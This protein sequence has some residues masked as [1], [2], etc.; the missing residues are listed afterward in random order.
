MLV[1]STDQGK[2]LAFVMEGGLVWR[3]T[4]V[5]VND[6]YRIAPNSE[7]I[8]KGML[9]PKLNVGLRASGATQF[10]A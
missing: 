9:H 7:L 2:V 8:G 6:I 10:R 1:A 4:L 5:S 3:A